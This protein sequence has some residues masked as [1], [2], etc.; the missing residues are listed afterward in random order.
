M[1]ACHNIPA[2][3]TYLRQQQKDMFTGLSSFIR[4]LTVGSGFAP[5]LLTSSHGAKWP[6]ESAL[7]GFL[8]PINYQ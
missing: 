6:H 5:N 2:V 7:A 8:L 1:N 4:T 3:V